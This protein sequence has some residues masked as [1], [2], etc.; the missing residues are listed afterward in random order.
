MAAPKGNTY[1]HA[2]KGKFRRGRNTKYRPRFCQEMIEYFSVKPYSNEVYK[3][4]KEYFVSGEVKSESNEKKPVP[5][6]MPTFYRFATKI[7]VNV[8]SLREWRKKN[9]KFASAYKECKELQKEFLINNGLSGAS[10][11]AAFIFTAK[12]VTDMRDKQELSVQDVTGIEKNKY[13]KVI[14][15]EQNSIKQRAVA[16]SPAG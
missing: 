10:P 13:A 8:E 2:K 11:A 7:N 3:E 6:P 9:G 12:N 5:A 16:D 14:Q 4:K 15:R 1:A